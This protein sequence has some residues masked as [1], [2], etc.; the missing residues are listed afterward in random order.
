M[1]RATK[2]LLDYFITLDRIQINNNLTTKKIEASLTQHEEDIEIFV[3]NDE[4]LDF[5]TK[6]QENLYPI[7]VKFFFKNK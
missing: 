1:L 4:D 7:I 2:N 3:T 6:N 5:M